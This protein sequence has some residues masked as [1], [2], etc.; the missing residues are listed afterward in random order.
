[1][2]HRSVVALLALSLAH[3][4]EALELTPSGIAVAGATA[5]LQVT[6]G[7]PGTNVHFFFSRSGEGRG[8]CAGGV[9]LG[10]RPGYGNA[11]FAAN[12]AGRMGSSPF[13][14]RNG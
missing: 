10:I 14:R 3:R 11:V 2:Q 5:T 9:C 7:S 4:A 13:N 12:P 8:A 6:G 1:M